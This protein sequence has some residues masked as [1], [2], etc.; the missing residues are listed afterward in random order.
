ME[1]TKTS[2]D[3]Y[4]ASLPE[5]SRDDIEK[6]D[7]LISKVMSDHSRVMWEGVFWSGSEQKIIGYGD[8]TYIGS[9]KKEVEW[10]VIGLTL[11]K[12]YISVYVNAVERKLNL[13][14]YK[15]KLGKAKVGRSSIG[16]NSL[17]DVKIDV[18]LEL[19]KKAKELAV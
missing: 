10:F 7:Q 5:A 6:L 17:S 4:I 12:N 11:Q 9:N 19:V 2:P 3:S 8:L 15:D 13:V 16:F 1:K 18:L 14:D